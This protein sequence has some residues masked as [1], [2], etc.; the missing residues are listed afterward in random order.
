MSYMERVPIT[1]TDSKMNNVVSQVNL[2]SQN[3]P[4]VLFS[5]CKPA[6]LGIIAIFNPHFDTATL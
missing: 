5:N 3:Q 1:R 2:K 6:R 4:F